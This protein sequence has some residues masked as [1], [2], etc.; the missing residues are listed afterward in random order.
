MA[1]WSSI[2]ICVH[3]F[4]FIREVVLRTLLLGPLYLLKKLS[5]LTWE[6]NLLSYCYLI[7]KVL[8]FKR[9]PQHVRDKLYLVCLSLNSII[10]MAYWSLFSIN[11][12]L[13][14]SYE[15]TKWDI[16]WVT[17]LFSHGGNLVFLVGEGVLIR[18]EFRAP[19]MTWFLQIEVVFVVFYCSMQWICRQVTGEAVYGFLDAMSITEVCTFYT[20]LGLI[21]LFVKS[22][23]SYALSSKSKTM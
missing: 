17:T 19:S 22:V 2:A 6:T 5:F 1:V 9:F 16:E 3:T 21:S 13:V 20:V 12:K 8:L 7:G 14:D 15:Y 10:V 11:P 4:F 23:A 18:K